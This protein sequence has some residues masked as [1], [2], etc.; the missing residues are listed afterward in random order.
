M[1]TI[2]T[3]RLPGGIDKVSSGESL[4]GEI[5]EDKQ[6]AVQWEAELLVL[7]EGTTLRF[8]PAF[9]RSSKRS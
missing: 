6:L 2:Y 3:A 4:E 9:C 1:A 8:F 7:I 5:W